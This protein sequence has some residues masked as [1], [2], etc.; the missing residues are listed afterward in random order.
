MTEKTE[1]IEKSSEKIIRGAAREI[2]ENCKAA[3]I[4]K[5]GEGREPPDR[6]SVIRLLND[7]RA[8]MFPGYFEFSFDTSE[9]RSDAER[10]ERAALNIYD[11]LHRQ[12]K[13]ALGHMC[14]GLDDKS[15]EK[16]A[17]EICA[18]F[19]KKLPQIHEK[20]LKD[21]KAGYA[22][23]PAAN[24]E[25]EVICCYPGF[26][27]ITV[28]RMAHEL[29]LARVPLIP[30]IMTEHAHDRTGIDINAGASIGEYFFIDHGTGVVIGETTVIGN[31]VKLYQGVTLGAISTRGG[32]NLSGVK[33]H[34]TVEDNVTIYAGATVLGGATVIGEGSVVGGNT[35]ITSSV[36]KNTKVSAKAPEL[37]F[38]EATN[39]E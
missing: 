18:D 15:A 17:G 25:E 9:C 8:L 23:D 38:K 13:K 35:V 20:L 34:P 29:Y 21:V 27:A 16:R 26:F 5:E 33:R 31:N 30:R 1:K 10:A 22:G 32:Q 28:Y 12:I 24:S 19:F 36:Q 39:R 4:I 7:I 14:G 37:N 6:G 3:E 2:L 11:S